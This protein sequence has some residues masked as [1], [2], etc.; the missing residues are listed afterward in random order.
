MARL[1]QGPGG[2]CALL[3]AHTR[4][5]AD[6]EV[7]ALLRDLS[8][9][10]RAG[11]PGCEAYVVTRVLGSRSHFAIHAQFEEH[12]VDNLFAQQRETGGSRSREQIR[13]E[14]VN[15]ED[16]EAN[17]LAPVDAQLNWLREIGF[18]DVGCFLQ[19]YELAV[20]AGWKS[21]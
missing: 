3:R 2:V 21:Q 10:V 19:I 12:F 14:F 8:Q 5:G 17:I 13:T 18:R 11:E 7:E 16:T 20:L 9:Q 15:R 4:P 1:L 6:D